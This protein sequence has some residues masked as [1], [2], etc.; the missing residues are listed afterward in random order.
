MQLLSL[1]LAFST[2]VLAALSLAGFFSRYSHWLD[3]CDHFRLQYLVL[4]S[5]LATIAAMSSQWAWGA[6]AA[7]FAV[8][9]LAV[10]FPIFL[11]PAGWGGGQAE[12]RL[13]LANVLRQNDSYGLLEDLIRKSQPDLIALVEPDQPWLD[14]LAALNDRYPHRFVAARPDNYGL[15]LLSRRPLQ[16]PQIHTLTSKGI[17]TLSAAVELDGVA[18]TLIVTH[19]PPPKNTCDLALRDE[20]LARLAELALN[21]PGERILCG[22]F[23]TTPWSRAFRRMAKQG[24]LLDSTAGFGYQPTWPVGKWWLRVP[25]DHCLVSKGI[26]VVR[27]KVAPRFGSDHY[28]LF[29]DF[30]ITRR[31][32]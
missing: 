32:A 26:L 10:I 9:N 21:Q 5:V 11:H 20:Q 14:G 24:H 8:F 12:F 17:P 19:P 16:H 25:I 6:L 2:G 31:E 1:L 27:R 28:P 18:I 3:I 4:L 7:G 15:A 13:L 29:I 22:D 30:S 23:N